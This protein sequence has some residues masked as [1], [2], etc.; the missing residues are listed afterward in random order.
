M[1]I[2]QARERVEQL[3]SQLNEASYQ[4][5]VLDRPEISDFE[6]DKLLRELEN[7]EEAFPEL[8][9]PNSP[10]VRVGG[11]ALSS[12][13]KVTHTV[14]MGSLQD[15]FSEQEMLQFDQRVREKLSEFQ[16]VVEPKIDGL[17]VSLEYRDGEFFRGSTRGDGFIGEDVTAN[18]RT[19][20]SIPLRLRET[21]PYL[22]VRGEVYM[23]REKFLKLVEQQEL[24][25]EQPFKNPRNAAAGSLRQKDSKIAAERGLD[26]FVF[27]IQQIEG[28][29]LSSHKESLDYLTSLGFK[30]VPQYKLVS[31]I[32][33]ALEEIRRIG[34]AREQF[35][36]DIDGAVVKIDDFNQRELLG[37]GAKY[38]KWAMAF[39]YPPE[40]K[41]TVLKEIE[42]NVGR[43][44]VLTPV[45]VF[46][47][48]LLA[49]TSVSRAVL[50]NQDFIDEKDIRIGD[51]I[52]VRKAGDIIPEVV[53]VVSHGEQ[54]EPFH[55]PENCPVC[56]SPVIHNEDEVAVRCEN[57]ECPATRLRNIIHFASRGAMNIEGLGIANVT[58]LV[59]QGLIQST[60]D[61]Y[62]LQKEELLNLERFADKSA[63]NLINAIQGSKQNPLWRLLFGLGIRNV[64]QSVAKLLCEKFAD[65]NQLM[66]AKPE[67]ISAIYG[68]GDVMADNIVKFFQQPKTKELIE[69][70]AQAGVNMKSEQVE[71]GTAL[72]G[73]TFVLT[74]TLPTMTR[75]QAKALIE[76]AGGKVTGSVSKKTSYVVAG[77]EAGS[78]L[79]KAQN[80]G[81]SIL[82]EEQLKELLAK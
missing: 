6:Y 48:I 50:H 43:T 46:D 65:I 4:Y 8:R 5:Y 35:S 70:L 61:L 57:P 33:Q 39:K 13:E 18:L 47:P 63:E 19:I 30:T 2:E 59:E 22:E 68:V 32:E 17:S 69:K 24:E 10:T 75:D 26:I 36:F 54:S 14:Q 9:S 31:N 27:N 73:L 80:L 81:I 66:E 3:T 60:A 40:E 44:G 72:Q 34:D 20:H 58:A 21:L 71:K 49:G 1:Q 29:E 64:G 52:L 42:V 76:A 74:G 25:E 82:K 51:T 53:A 11:Q 67:D 41:P 62:S 23:P 7:L 56:G 77:E 12:F 38:P 15:A 37:A 16:Y 28:K 79:T 55:L 78:K 45:A